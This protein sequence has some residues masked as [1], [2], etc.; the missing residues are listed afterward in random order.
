MGQVQVEGVGLSVFDVD[1]HEG[2]SNPEACAKSPVTIHLHRV[3]TENALI[4]TESQICSALNPRFFGSSFGGVLEQMIA[5]P[6]KEP[7]AKR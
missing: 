7:A 6:E 2:N 4:F 1:Y 3:S 5:H